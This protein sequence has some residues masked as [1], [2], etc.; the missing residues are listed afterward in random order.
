MDAVVHDPNG[1]WFVLNSPFPFHDTESGVL[2]QPG[3]VVKATPTASTRNNPRLSE[4]PDPTG[5]TQ[6]PK[7]PSA[8]KVKKSED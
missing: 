8:P 6:K 1:K 7:E 2:F 3:V 4:V 5:A